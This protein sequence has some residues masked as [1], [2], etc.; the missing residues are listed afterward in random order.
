M[1]KKQKTISHRFKYLLPIAVSLFFFLTLLVIR[2]R[3]EK[4]LLAFYGIY[5]NH[6]Q[7]QEAALLFREG[8]DIL[9]ETVRRY[10]VTT[11]LA[12]RDAYFHEANQVKHRDQALALLDTLP[13]GAKVKEELVEAMK[14]SRELMDL[15]YHAMR[16]ITTQEVLDSHDCPSPIYNYPINSTE[17]QSSQEERLSR[18]QKLLFGQQ[19]ESYKEQIYFFVDRSFKNATQTLENQLEQAIATQKKLYVYL[20]LDMFALLLSIIVLVFVLH[21]QR[22]RANAFLRQILDNM[23]LLFRLKNARTECYLDANTAF[24]Q[25]AGKQS[26]DE[27]RGKDDYEIFEEYTAKNLTDNDA[28]TLLSHAPITFHDTLTDA[29]GKQ[30]RLR[31]TQFKLEDGYGTPCIFGM[32]ADVTSNEEVNANANALAEVLYCLQMDSDLTAPIHIL[33]LIRERIDADYA[34]LVRYDQQKGLC[35]IDMGAS[36]DRHNVPIHDT[37]TCLTK[38][39]SLIVHQ[40]HHQRGHLFSREDLS[41]L[42]K[43]C[44]DYGNGKTALPECATMIAFPIFVHHE[45]WGNLSLAFSIP[46]K[47]NTHE[48]DFCFRCSEVLSFSV[49][50]LLHYQ[51]LQDAL[52]QALAA[53]EADLEATVGDDADPPAPSAQ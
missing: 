44:L 25:F 40:I 11:D 4:N 5:Q 52:D 48:K 37:I 8:T 21:T 43:A 30:R 35:T 16:L 17:L 38:D 12:A 10:S 42:R 19:Y 7:Y 3:M 32:A 18:A 26:L 2:D 41:T 45:L 9:T 33:Q 31:V 24:L 34:L 39:I 6:N 1:S 29:S 20:G 15:E 46:H 22:T 13:G 49:E 14:Y 47:L 36:I 27:I 51:K 53:S 23:P 28:K 50:R